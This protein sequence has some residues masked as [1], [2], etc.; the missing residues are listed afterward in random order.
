MK[1][2]ISSALACITFFLS[3]CFT[4]QVMPE[5]NIDARVLD[6]ETGKPISGAQLYMVYK[7]A[8]VRERGPFFTDHD[9]FSKI[10]LESEAIWQ[11]GAYA[12]FAGGY[13]R[14]IKVEAEGYES[15]GYWESFNRGLL[16]EKSPFVFKML[17][18]RNRFG[19]VVVIMHDRGILLGSN[20]EREGDRLTMRVL[21]GPDEGEFLF[22][23]IRPKN[24]ND[25]WKGRVFYLLR[26][27]SDFKRDAHAPHTIALNLSLFLREG[28]IN[29][30]YSPPIRLAE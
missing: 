28:D 14:H 17:S 5:V 10:V 24:P 12:G 26:P 4:P 13:L 2:R 9:G 1:L 22:V 29:E 21:D 7:G 27:F 3:G 18:R 30:P 16:D 25:D 19:A 6:K 8:D 23:P 15:T 20:R 11:S